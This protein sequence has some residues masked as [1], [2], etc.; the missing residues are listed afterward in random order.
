[1]S[2][3]RRSMGWGIVV[4]LVGAACTRPNYAYEGTDGG[5]PTNGSATAVATGLSTGA[6]GADAGTLESG[7]G[8]AEP[9]VTDDDCDDGTFC[10]GVE[11]C[12]PNAELADARGCVPG[13]S[14]C[15][16]NSSCL[17]GRQAC[18]DCTEDADF[19]D[20]TFA[21]VACG[22]DDCNDEEPDIHPGA[23]EACDDVDD[24]CNPE[25]LGNLDR[26]G[27][28]EIS[29]TCCNP[30]AEG[31]RCGSDCDDARP[32]I[33]SLGSD[34]AHCAACGESC[35]PL[36]ACVQ[37][38]CQAARRVFVTS[39]VLSGLL[40]GL[41][42]ADSHCNALANDA[43]LEGTFRAFLI[44]GVHGLERLEQANVPYMRLDGVQ[45]AAHWEELVDGTLMAPFDRDQWRDVVEGDGGAV[46]AWT[47]LT[48]LP[49]VIQADVHCNGWT[50]DEASCDATM[51]CGGAGVI[52]ATN[53]SWAGIGFG[54]SCGLLHH[55]YCIEQDEG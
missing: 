41:D 52:G 53:S 23:V 15:P 38:G 13:S 3:A 21:A 25:T 19:D 14:P 18:L 48:M 2:N 47:G 26:D 8:P 33:G 27:D 43:G 36:Q 51:I 10:N 29:D 4:A 6:T 49:V 44:D 7:D 50:T 9:C 24:D 20:D 40:G 17:E 35:D 16:P 39:D 45:I 1:M 55:L 54:S 11:A 37:G 34:W 46:L 12:K 42:G 28:G 31:Y 5:D 30:S 32:G 22:G